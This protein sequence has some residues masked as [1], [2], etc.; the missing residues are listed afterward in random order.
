M[1][2]HLATRQRHASLFALD[3]SK[4]HLD[5]LGPHASSV[6]AP[7]DA[8]DCLH[9]LMQLAHDPSHCQVRHLVVD[10]LLHVRAQ[11]LGAF[12]R[13]ALE[14][15]GGTMLLHDDVS[16]RRDIHKRTQEYSPAPSST[17]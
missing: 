17:V 12:E 4:V 7:D 13:H 5:K 8:Q 16:R 15:I 11:L 1:R 14:P 2:L 9:L 3:R 6:A 10:P